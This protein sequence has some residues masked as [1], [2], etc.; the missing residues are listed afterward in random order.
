M[1][2]AR[3]RQALNKQKRTAQGLAAQAA[4]DAGGTQAPAAPKLAKIKKKSSKRLP[5]SRLKAS[6]WPL[7]GSTQKKHLDRLK[8]GAAKKA[9][10]GAGR[11]PGA[12][13]VGATHSY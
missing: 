3:K 10:A 4:T 12:F 6:R 9:A 5:N 1:G 8:P 2:Q 11:T 13:G 7:N